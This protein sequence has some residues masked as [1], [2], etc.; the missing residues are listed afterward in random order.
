MERSP[1]YTG[2][3][4]SF[5]FVVGTTAS[6]FEKPLY[7]CGV[8]MALM[9]IYVCLGVREY[10]QDARMRRDAFKNLYELRGDE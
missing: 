1:N 5:G 10:R 9:M 7:M 8:G 6:V 2:F 4:I 3:L